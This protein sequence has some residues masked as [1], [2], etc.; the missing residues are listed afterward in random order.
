MLR[1][2]FA[3]LVVLGLA[4]AAAAEAPEARTGFFPAGQAYAPPATD[5]PA[6]ASRAFVRTAVPVN[7]LV[8]LDV[9]A[10]GGGPLLVW[11][12]QHGGDATSSP[13]A[14]L[15]TPGQRALGASE[16][17]SADGSLRRFTLDARESG[18]DLPGAREAILVTDAEAGRH[19]LE[20]RVAGQAAAVTV[21][22]AEPESPLTLSAWAGPLSRQPGQPVSLHAL[23]RDGERALFGAKVSARLAA[24][25][26]PAGG[27]I[28]LYDDGRHGD[29]A[30]AD[31]EYAATVDRIGDEAAGLW[32]VRFEATG[33]DAQGL[34]FART[35]G[36]GFMSERGSARLGPVRA[37]L[38]EANGERRLRVEA[39]AAADAPGRYRLDVVVAGA[40]ANGGRPSLAWS[41][42]SDR[43]SGPQR[44][45]ADIPLP[46]GSAGP[47]LLDVRLLGL[48]VPGLAGRT[49]I[50][51]G[52]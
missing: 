31:G 33:R 48:D 2:P 8:R 37:R 25:G 23:L 47:Y 45:G 7:G 14:A 16:S 30:A 10:R 17:A 20:V 50:E 41:E 43:L 32:S 11:T 15:R 1:S 38:I 51:V 12:L 36:S 28:L 19:R 46:A 39:E 18:I 27:A 44:L 24:P 21:V 13:R 34:A 3:L 6:A 26:R 9:P 5:A 4:A 52:P 42:T 29:G 40:P 22:A 49:T 35:G